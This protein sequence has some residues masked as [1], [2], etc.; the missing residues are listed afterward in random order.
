MVEPILCATLRH[1]GSRSIFVVTAIIFS[2]PIDCVNNEKSHL[3]LHGK[4]V[5]KVGKILKLNYF[6]NKLR[7][8]KK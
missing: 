4:S 3:A 2:T 8:V 6:H 5:V 1:L 7:S